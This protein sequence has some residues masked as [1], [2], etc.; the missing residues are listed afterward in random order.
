MKV[1]HEFS[2]GST[3]LLSSWTEDE[4]RTSIYSFWGD[5]SELG[6]DF[7]LEERPVNRG[8]QDCLFLAVSYAGE[9][10]GEYIPSPLHPDREEVE[11]RLEGVPSWA[12][13]SYASPQGADHDA[14]KAYIV[15]LLSPGRYNTSVAWRRVFDVSPNVPV[16]RLPPSP[17]RM[18]V[19]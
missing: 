14:G 12:W 5:N 4:W 19:G 10:E 11:K 9:V 3:H 18:S 13:R 1:L 15:A 7:P 16:D 6:S 17:R 8:R 2:V